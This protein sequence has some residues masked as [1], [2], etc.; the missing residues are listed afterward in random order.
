MQNKMRILKQYT[1]KQLF[2]ALCKAE[3]IGGAARS[4][5]MHVRTFRARL[6]EAMSVNTE[7]PTPRQEVRTTDTSCSEILPNKEIFWDKNYDDGFGKLKIAD[8]V[9]GSCPNPYVVYTQ[10]PAPVTYTVFSNFD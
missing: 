7:V 3:S 6:D 9:I 8:E 2:D 4:L 1:R 5:G 10:E